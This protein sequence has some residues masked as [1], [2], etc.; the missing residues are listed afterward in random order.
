MKALLFL[1]ILTLSPW[2][3]IAFLFCTAETLPA[4]DTK[5]PNIILILADDMGYGDVSHAGGLAATPHID[6]VRAEGMRFTD[7]YAG[8]T[9][10]A[11][12]RAV[13][14]TGQH[15]G[16]NDIRG[17]REVRPMGQHP[18]P[19]ER[20]TVAV[21]EVIRHDEDDVRFLISHGGCKNDESDDSPHHRC[22][23]SHVTRP[24]ILFN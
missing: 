19:A 8:S 11:P 21:A 18:L 5:R 12:S 10:C 15:T 23:N 24:R 4:S 3:G 13:L 16:H 17:N 2:F 14:M 22:S 6:R 20:V 1:R 9:V 7:F